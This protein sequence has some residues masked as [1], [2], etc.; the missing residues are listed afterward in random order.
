MAAGA[1]G[2]EIEVLLDKQLALLIRHGRV[3][4]SSRCR[5]AAPGY[6]TPPGS[7]RIYRKELQSWSYPYGVTSPYLTGLGRLA[8]PSA[9]LV[10][11]PT[12]PSRASPSHFWNAT[13][14]WRVASVNVDPRA[15]SGR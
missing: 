12:S 5:P 6:A 1:R 4:A 8:V 14:A 9:A 2:R 15:P 3:R 10:C 13:T 11:G 7:F